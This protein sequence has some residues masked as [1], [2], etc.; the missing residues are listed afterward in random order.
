MGYNQEVY[1]V[2]ADELARRRMDAEHRANALRAR[3]TAQFPRVT[4]LELQMRG[5][6]AEVARAVINGGDVEGIVAEVRRRNE[7][8]Q[9]E[10]AAIL[11]DAGET[12]ANFAPQYTCA[13]CA[14]TGYVG[15]EMCDCF[16]RLLADGA[17]KR[18]SRLSGMELTSLDDMDLSFYKDRLA[19]SKLLDF[20]RSYGE[21]FS[22]ES[23]S[24]LLFGPTGVGKTHVSLALASMAAQ[25]GYS[26]MYGPTQ[27]LLGQMEREHF[28]RDEG[29][30]GELLADADL[31]VLDDLGT[32]LTGSFYQVSLYNLINTRLLTKRPTI[33][34]TNLSP[35][36]LQSRYGVQIASRILGTYIPLP[37]KGDDIRQQK[38][39]R[40][41]G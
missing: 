29:N 32:E 21:N 17:A 25:K 33:I 4:E 34:S 14:D 3:I 6:A 36:E 26:V 13:R 20:C 39:E 31:L 10:L 30:T 27:Q 16:R 28:G 5:S 19:M 37:F 15:S 11:A 8:A 38:L 23:D 40:R 41:L 2:A 12:A 18:L 1:R 35:A 7:A 9:T 24:L 22:E